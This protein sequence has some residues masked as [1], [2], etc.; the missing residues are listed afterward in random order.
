MK[1]AAS[2]TFSAPESIQDICERHGLPVILCD[3]QVTRRQRVHVLYRPDARD[4]YTDYDLVECLNRCIS[5]LGGKAILAH[6]D[7]VGT[8]HAC[9]IDLQPY[10]L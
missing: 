7:K 8:L 1:S 2:P 6:I 9:L 4:F 10:D 3:H 5:N